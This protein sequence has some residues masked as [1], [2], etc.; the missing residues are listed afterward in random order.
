MISELVAEQC[1]SK[2]IGPL[3]GV[4]CEISHWL[5]RGTKKPLPKNL[6]G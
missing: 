3:R 6:E 5:E 4:D 2:D 1:A